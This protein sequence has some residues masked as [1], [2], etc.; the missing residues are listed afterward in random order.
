MALADGFSLR[1]TAEDAESAAVVDLLASAMRLEPGRAETVLR[2]TTGETEAL[3]SI[4]D[5]GIL[6]R[7]LPPEN[8]EDAVA[9][10]FQVSLVIAHIARKR[11]GLLVHGGFA[12]F[13]DRGF[14]LAAPGG[15]G[16][17]TAVS[18]VPAAWKPLSDDA[19]LIVP[20]SGNRYWGHPWPTWSRF[21]F[22][23]PGGSWDVGHGVPL[24]ALCFLAQSPSDTLETLHP[25]Q[26]AAMLMESAQQAHAAFNRRLPP[27]AVHENH[28]EQFAV[29]CKMTDTVPCYRLHL[30][31][32]G[33]FWTNLE[34]LPEEPR[35]SALRP[36]ARGGRVNLFD[37][38][39]T[40]GLGV[41]LS[42]SSMSPT[43]S[44]PGYALV[45]PYNGQRPRAGDVIQFRCPS[46]GT[47]IIHRVMEVR[48]DGLVT[49]GDHN[50]RNDPG[51]VPL[52]AVDGLVV[53]VKDARGNRR[54][55]QGRL[56]MVDFTVSRLKR[57]AGR[58]AVQWIRRFSGSRS[59][60][61]SLRRLVPKRPGWKIVFF[62]HPAN[63][64]LKIMVK[65]NCVGGYERGVWRIAYPWRLRIDPVRLDPAV[66]W[67]EREREKWG[68][69][70]PEENRKSG[71]LQENEI[72]V[73][74]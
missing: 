59:L 67:L 60:T 37:P 43:L 63:G 20:G 24:Q 35:P 69:G 62:G 55:R 16:K 73:R 44:E 31:L 7:I 48:P 41:V 71:S 61:S 15:T 5:D 21:F 17:T 2:V 11:G 34:A 46:T 52:S 10:A 14:I 58:T 27:A 9:R 64:L 40:G 72:G 32:H 4:Q 30:S 68:S 12:A 3:Y 38:V 66:T 13:Q 22:S 42:G 56:G 65:E 49:R 50:D 19:V 25:G 57:R 29:V 36:A 51:I 26:A 47:S 54:V 1:I 70:Q 23:G 18:R 28:L 45:R 33:D 53:W 74:D 6:C 39:R 8:R